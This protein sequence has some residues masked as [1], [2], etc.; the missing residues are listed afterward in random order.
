MAEEKTP[1][2]TV[3]KLEKNNWMTFWPNVYIHVSINSTSL[4]R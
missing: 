2:Q 1:G 4:Q 3:A